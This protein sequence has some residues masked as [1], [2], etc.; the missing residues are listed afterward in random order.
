MTR[1]RV[2]VALA[3]FLA[4]GAATD[5]VTPE[6]A[7]QSTAAARPENTGTIIYYRDPDGKPVYS[8][9]PRK[10]A[11]G[12][13][14]VAVL[15]SEDV[16]FEKKKP[17]PVREAEGSKQIRFYRNPMGLP[18]TSPKPKKDSMGMDYIP[19]Y[20][21]EQ[22][23]GKT[24][25]IT[26]GKL[27]RTGV[28]SEAASRRILSTAIRAP[29]TVRVDERKQSV[30]APRFEAFIEKLENVTTGSVVKK[31]QPLVRLYSPALSTAAAQYLTDMAAGRDATLASGRGT[32]RRLENLG[33]PDTIIKEIERTKEAPLSVIWP[34]PLDGIITE[35]NV[36]EGMR[37]QTGDV[38]FRLADI[39]TVWVLAD[40]TERDLSL[41]AIGQTATV[42]PRA[43]AGQTFT[44]KLTLIYPAINKETR[45]ARVRIELDNGEGRLMPEMYADVDIASGSE[46]PVIAVPDSAVIDS[47]GATIVI[48]D[49]G[50][51]RFEPR[52][53]KVGR[54]GGGYLEIREGLTEGEKVVIAANFLI[55]AESNLKSALQALAPQ[56]LQ[57][58]GE[59]K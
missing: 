52:E 31:G 23:D 1:A 35:N 51:G 4:A 37:V 38:L 22:E 58:Q 59:T 26:P 8:P 45:T 25:T 3:G 34:A 19:V 57:A 28:R 2:C 32:R 24:V 29:G 18:D 42:R 48:A 9:T 21:G 27:Q 49:K 13:E 39:S 46:A 15:A 33:I 36:V 5:W 43:Y 44:G 12:R 10:T 56:A 11:D 7:A 6:G 30:I 50:E 47:G 53:V 20:E 54:R 17:A 40:V 55:D 16:S 41:I 14:F